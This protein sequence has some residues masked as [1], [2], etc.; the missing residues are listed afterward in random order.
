MLPGHFKSIKQYL[1]SQCGRTFSEYWLSYCGSLLNL[2]KVALLLYGSII[3]TQTL[4]DWK[5][6]EVYN[7][8]LHSILA[9]S[10]HWLNDSATYLLI[11]IYSPVFIAANC[12]DNSIIIAIS[13]DTNVTV[14][15]V[16]D[17]VEWFVCNAI[18]SAQIHIN[19]MGKH[20]YLHRNS[21]KWLR[22]GLTCHFTRLWIM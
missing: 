18:L 21:S 17:S 22:A 9:I 2:L 10:S 3:S 1:W 8:V 19:R 11:K 13:M 14:C 16:H 6:L 12:S 7:F 15:D 5:G 20:S 4:R